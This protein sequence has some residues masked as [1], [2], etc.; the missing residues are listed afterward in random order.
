MAGLSLAG[1]AASY[2][3]QNGLTREATA[4][5]LLTI[6]WFFDRAMMTRKIVD[7]IK[8]KVK[9]DSISERARR[10]SP[11]LLIHLSA[12]VSVAAVITMSDGFVPWTA[13]APFLLA[14]AKNVA[15]TFSVKQ[16]YNPMKTG[17][18]EMRL[19]MAFGLIMVIAWRI[20][21]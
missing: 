16:D 3:Q 17:F 21:F 9:F 12:L 18:S 8:G 19:G 6:I 11:Q 13:F 10:Y 1:P 14:T 20:K 2:V 5:Y 7:S 4:L 15:D